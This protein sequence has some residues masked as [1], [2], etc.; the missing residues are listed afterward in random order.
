MP[1][2][3]RI[4]TSSAI[5]ARSLGPVAPQGKAR[6]LCNALR[7]RLFAKCVI[8]PNES[9]AGFQELH[10]PFVD[11]F[12]PAAGVEDDLVEEGV[13]ASVPSLPGLDSPSF[14]ALRSG[15]TTSTTAPCSTSSSRAPP[16]CQTNPTTG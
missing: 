15:S 1:S 10:D 12:G 16:P 2:L 7:H 6:P 5:V 11:R 9:P 13:T 4:L 3:C 14:F 8:L